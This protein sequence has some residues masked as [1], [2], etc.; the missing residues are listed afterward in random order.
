MIFRKK[1]AKEPRKYRYQKPNERYKTDVLCGEMRLWDLPEN[2]R[3]SGQCCELC[4][5][6]FVVCKNKYSY[7]KET[8]AKARFLED[9]AFI[10]QEIIDAETPVQRENLLHA[11]R[12]LTIKGAEYL[13]LQD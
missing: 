10:E 8:A 11:F 7:G 5:T 2:I 6:A 12:Y 1:H 9:Y 3:R 13:W 4:S